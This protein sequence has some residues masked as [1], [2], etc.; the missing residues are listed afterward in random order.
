MEITK[1]FT[2]YDEPFWEIKVPHF[3]DIVATELTDDSPVRID[4]TENM[5]FKVTF[6]RPSSVEDGVEGVR[7]ITYRP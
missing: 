7:F 3:G 5:G 1:V 2:K 4:S 6:L